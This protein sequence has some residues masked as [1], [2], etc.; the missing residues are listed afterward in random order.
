MT[1]ENDANERQRGGGDGY[2]D[3]SAGDGEGLGEY[4]PHQLYSWPTEEASGPS[5]Q[6]ARAFLLGHMRP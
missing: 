1:K 3:P 6:G 4:W 5:T 2:V